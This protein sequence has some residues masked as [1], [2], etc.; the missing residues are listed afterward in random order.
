MPIIANIL[1][2]NIA[3]VSGSLSCS[4]F[5]GF[6]PLQFIVD[7][8]SATTTILPL[9]VVK[10]EIDCTRLRK[11]LRPLTTAKGEIFPYILP[12]VQL[13]LECNDG[14]ID[15]LEMF[16]LE[17]IHCIKPRASHR[18]DP[19]L[20]FRHTFSLLG[21]D[22]LKYFRKWIWNFENRTLTLDYEL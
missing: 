16:P 12:D 21:M 6:K 14:R 15:A 5:T 1:S 8:G 2:W 3:I 22:V 20:L 17:R 19:N 7:S 13:N 4:Q 18:T 11:G 9:E 10:L